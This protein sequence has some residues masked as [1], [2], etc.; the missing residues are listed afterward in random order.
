MCITNFG[1]LNL[2]EFDLV[3]H[4]VFVVLSDLVVDFDVVVDFDLIVRSDL[5]VYFDLVV[6][7]P[8]LPVC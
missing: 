2:V 1:L 7:S 4:S 3:F 6:H 8:G 5:V